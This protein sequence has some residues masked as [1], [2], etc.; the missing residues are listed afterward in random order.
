MEPTLYDGDLLLVDTR[1][2]K[3]MDDAIYIIQD[4]H[5]L[6]VKRVQRTLGGALAIISDNPKYAT[7][8]LTSHQAQSLKING[9]V[10]WYGHEI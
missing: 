9:R 3:I 10:C 7:Q 1:I 6:V 8:H 5:H 4:N 2:E